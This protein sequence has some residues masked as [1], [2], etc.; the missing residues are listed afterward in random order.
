MTAARNAVLNRGYASD[1]FLGEGYVV[2]WLRYRAEVPR[3][4]ASA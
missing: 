4:Y 2:S 3:A 1:R